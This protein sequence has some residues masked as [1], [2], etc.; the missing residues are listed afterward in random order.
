MP[1]KQTTQTDREYEAR[2]E[3]LKR[4][5]GFARQKERGALTKVTPLFQNPMI[6]LYVVRGGQLG[7]QFIPF[8]DDTIPGKH[9][10]HVCGIPCSPA[11]VCLRR[12]E[13]H[14]ERLDYFGRCMLHRLLG[15]AVARQQAWLKDHG[16]TE[17]RL[18][19]VWDRLAADVPDGWMSL[20][21]RIDEDI[22]EMGGVVGGPA[23]GQASLEGF[24]H[25]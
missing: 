15:V 5:R 25:E 7:F 20:S 1:F 23:L 18:G 3:K 13:S 8:A 24:T 21:D 9:P 2:V 22:I 10:C 11:M 17:E 14:E 6:V 16:W 19:S 4:K 12:P